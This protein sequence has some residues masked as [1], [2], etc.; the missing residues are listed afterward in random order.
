MGIN[1][2]KRLG[3]M[4]SIFDKMK[5]EEMLEKSKIKKELSKRENKK[6]D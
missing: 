3:K 5:K 1:C 4:K 2:S 6:N